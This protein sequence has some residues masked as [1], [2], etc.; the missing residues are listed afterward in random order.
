MEKLIEKFY[1]L[2]N[3]YHKQETS[4]QR[5]AEIF[6]QMKSY[7]TEI[8]HNDDQYEYKRAYHAGEIV[9]INQCESPTELYEILAD[10]EAARTSDKLTNIAEQCRNQQKKQN[11]YSADNPYPHE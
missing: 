10:I 4:E 5:K 6:L 9:K 1:E 2:K 3:E 11:K 8:N 7:L